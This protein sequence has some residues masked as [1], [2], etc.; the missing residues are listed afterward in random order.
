MRDLTCVEVATAFLNKIKSRENLNAVIYYNQ[1]EVLAE[2]A[3]MDQESDAGS[4][5]GPLHGA[6][7]CIKDSRQR[8]AKHRWNSRSKRVY[9]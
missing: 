5:R 1:D 8:Y 7:L 4:F 6:P 9:S 2:A 3:K